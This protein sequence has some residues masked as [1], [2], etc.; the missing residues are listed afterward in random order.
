LHELTHTL[1]LFRTSETNF[2]ISLNN[3]A[4]SEMIRDVIMGEKFEEKNKKIL[5]T[6]IK[7]SK[8]PDSFTSSNKI[9]RAKTA[10]DF[11]GMGI[12]VKTMLGGVA[13][14]TLKLEALLPRPDFEEI[15]CG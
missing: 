7:L 6:I 1:P 11:S 15:N 4:N 2:Q 8:L 5:N 10:S 12:D 13:S 14:A 3:P 9:K